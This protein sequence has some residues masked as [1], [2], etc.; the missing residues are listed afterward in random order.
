MIFVVLFIIVAILAALFVIIFLISNKVFNVAVKAKVPKA[1]VIE[2]NASDSAD[3]DRSEER[4]NRAWLEA[5]LFEELHITAADNTPLFGRI[6]CADS[7]SHKWA[8]ICHGFTGSGL[9]MGSCSHHFHTA[10][11]NILLPDLRGC[12]NSGGKYYGMGWL[13]SQDMLLWIKQVL[14]RDPDAKIVL[15]GGSMGGAT[16]MMTTGLDLPAN[17]VAAVEDCGYTTVWDEFTHQLKKVFGL[18]QFPFLH[19]ANIMAKRRAGYSFKEASS[20]DRVKC[21]HTP[22]LFI[23]GTAD[24][25]VPFSMLDEN[26]KAAACPKQRL[27]VE[28]AGHGVS[29]DVSPQLYWNTVDSF[30]AEYMGE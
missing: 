12:G 22:T 15:T 10:G 28:G 8:V 25:F 11:Y 17:V 9:K 29:M 6:L 19:I 5:K 16:V 26:Y 30:L 4:A 3:A 21:S 24:E 7:F 2:T 23:H 1:R 14:A 20:I 13:D 27:A 18:P